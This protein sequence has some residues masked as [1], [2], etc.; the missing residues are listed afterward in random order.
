MTEVEIMGLEDG[1]KGA[2]KVHGLFFKVIMGYHLH[3]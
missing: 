3:Q 2:R 1:R